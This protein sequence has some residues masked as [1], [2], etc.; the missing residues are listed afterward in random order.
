[1]TDC[2]GDVNANLVELALKSK[3]KYYTNLNEAII[4]T[5]HNSQN[6]LNIEHVFIHSIDKALELRGPTKTSLC[7]HRDNFVQ[8]S[9]EQYR[10]RV[11]TPMLLDCT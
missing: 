4:L 3:K 6:H 2:D 10:R 9:S 8:S 7:A 11:S 1:M 5:I